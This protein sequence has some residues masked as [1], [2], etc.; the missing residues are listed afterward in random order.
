MTTR[1]MKIADAPLFPSQSY[2]VGTWACATPN[3][4]KPTLAPANDGT[5]KG[6]S[7]DAHLAALFGFDVT[8]VGGAGTVQFTLQMFDPVSGKWYAVSPTIQSAVIAAASSVTL[9]VFPG[10]LETANAR[11][12]FVLP[13]LFRIIA[14]VAGN[15]VTFS[16]HGW[17]IDI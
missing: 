10:T 2:A 17:M 9:L 7:S 13:P 16:G 3:T 5:F 1:N 8:A 12:S 11:F 14:V 6:W 4:A 15:A